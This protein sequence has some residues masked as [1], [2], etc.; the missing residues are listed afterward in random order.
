[1]IL[2]ILFLLLGIALVG[3]LLFALIK[4][5]FYRSFATPMIGMTGAILI[6]APVFSVSY[7]AI[8]N[9]SAY[10]TALNKK[11]ELIN[12]YFEAENEEEQKDA[13]F[14]VESH[15]REVD[16]MARKAKSPWFNVFSYAFYSDDEK[17][18][19]LKI[20]IESL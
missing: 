2:F 20:T 14:H 19:S 17:A 7:H 18:S 3:Y 13:L 8:H 9:E 10:Q 5:S 11:Q 12:A 15:N 16:E 6:L 1:M 4:R